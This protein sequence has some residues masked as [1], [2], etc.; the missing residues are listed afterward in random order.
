MMT[1]SSNVM[2]NDDCPGSP[3]LL[4][5][6]DGGE[7]FFSFLLRSLILSTATTSATFLPCP[8]SSL[9]VH[10]VASASS[11]SF[12]E[13]ESPSILTSSPIYNSHS[14]TLSMKSL[15]KNIDDIIA[16]EEENSPTTNVSPAQNSANNGNNND[17]NNNNNNGFITKSGLKFFD[18]RKGQGTTTPRWG[19]AVIFH[20]TG[21][22][23]SPVDGKL[24]K[25]DSSFDR[26]EPFVIKHGNGRLIRGLDE[27]IHSMKVGGYRR[28][29]IPP[30]LSYVRSGLGPIPPDPFNRKTL[31]KEL[32]RI[33]DLEK[34]TKNQNFPEGGQG[35]GA[36]GPLNKNNYIVYDIELLSI[37]DDESDQG[38]YQDRTMKPEEVAQG[39]NKAINAIMLNRRRELEEQ[40]KQQEQESFDFENSRQGDLQG[41]IR[42][43]QRSGL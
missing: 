36:G 42:G 17:N 4:M 32:D 5:R 40:K 10:T 27:G 34:Q 18:I 39:Q 20:Y 19:Q 23:R 43:V 13:S 1:S 9:A 21:Y 11:T 8:C 41:D 15:D 30:T 33:E 31:I 24:I 22:I 16:A 12:S 28:M 35:Q 3:S 14:L 26:K 6:K 25:F 38:Y 2:H 29:L 7:F 37:Y